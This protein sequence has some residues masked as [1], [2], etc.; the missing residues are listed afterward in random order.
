M[1]LSCL[2]E[3]LQ[4]RWWL[5]PVVIQCRVLKSSAPPNTSH[6]TQTN[7]FANVYLKESYFERIPPKDFE[8][9]QI[10]YPLLLTNIEILLQSEHKL[11]DCR[12]APACLTPARCFCQD[13]E[14]L[15]RDIWTLRIT[16]F[17]QLSEFIYLFFL[18]S[19]KHL[20]ELETIY[21]HVPI[22]RH[23]SKAEVE[24]RDRTH[25]CTIATTIA[26][27]VDEGRHFWTFEMSLKI[28]RKCPFFARFWWIDI[29]GTRTS[30]SQ[31]GCEIWTENSPKG[32]RSDYKWGLV[33]RLEK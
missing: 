31:R 15:A 21:D 1:H 17:L 16:T 25:S 24:G 10:K 33:H 8:F 20:L 5:T 19:K 27:A 26:R 2:T 14:Q 9:E 12:W 13:P 23:Q 29:F 28:T 7:N 32:D 18:F 4:E 11:R 22:H 6:R 30:S 3:L